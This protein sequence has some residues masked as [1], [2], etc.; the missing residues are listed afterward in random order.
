[1]EGENMTGKQRLTAL[2]FNKPKDRIPWTTLVDDIT[3]S[4]MPE[5]IR[6]MHVMDFYRYIGCDIFQFG[7]YGL[8]PED[9]VKYPF[10]VLRKDIKDKWEW[11][12]SQFLRHTIETPW[13]S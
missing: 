1:M 7:N 3:R 2:L 12:D 8:K 6:N 9:A 13:E 11:L 4:V 5:D 10:K